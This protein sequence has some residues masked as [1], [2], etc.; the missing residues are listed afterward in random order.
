MGI[1]CHGMRHRPWRRLDKRS[2]REEVVD[3][4]RRL[5]QVVGRPVMEAACPFGAY[6]RRVLRFLR[7]QGYSRAYSSDPG[8]AQPD[9]WLQPRNTVRPGNAAGLIDRLVADVANQNGLGR[10]ARLTA[11]RWR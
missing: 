6:D 11:K 2:L 10:R 7:R 9:D 4:R 8:M 3:A 1:G 5:E